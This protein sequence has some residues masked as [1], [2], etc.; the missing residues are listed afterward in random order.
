V[1]NVVVVTIMGVM[2]VFSLL[3]LQMLLLEDAIED[4][5][6]RRE[7]RRVGARGLEAVMEVVRKT[8]G[9]VARK[10]VVFEVGCRFYRGERTF[11]LYDPQVGG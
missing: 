3:V 1:V 10:V 2:V 6:E 4:A 7:M 8:T 11:A 5:R 9:I